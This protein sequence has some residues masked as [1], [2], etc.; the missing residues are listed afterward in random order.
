L[1]IGRGISAFLVL[2]GV[3]T[4]ILWPNFLKNIWADDKSWN[5]GATAFFVVHLLLTIV[6]F[7]AGNAI[8][9]IGIK[10]LRAS[11]GAAL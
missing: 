1:R 7:V 4:W 9:W 5:D 6:S 11:R 8:G 3:W 10:G 2:F